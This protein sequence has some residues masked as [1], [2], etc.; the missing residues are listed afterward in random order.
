MYSRKEDGKFSGR[1]SWFGMNLSASA[2]GVSSV[3]MKIVRFA[4]VDGVTC[5]ARDCLYDC[6]VGLCLLAE[7]D[8]G[9]ARGA[10]LKYL[11]HVPEVVAR[12]AHRVALVEVAI[13][14]VRAFAR[15]CTAG[16]ADMLQSLV[17]L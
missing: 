17:L 9:V 10:S 3:W 2:L 5:L 12:R 4:C 13:G 15:H 1:T 7:E 11:V 6:I 16:L 8:K 14:R